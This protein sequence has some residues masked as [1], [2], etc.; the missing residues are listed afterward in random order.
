MP[1]PGL[2]A[3][4]EIAPEVLWRDYGSMLGLTV[5]LIGFIYAFHRKGRIGRGAG[6]VLLLGYFSYLGLLLVQA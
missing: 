4:T 1:I 2:V 5:L 3:T 6:S